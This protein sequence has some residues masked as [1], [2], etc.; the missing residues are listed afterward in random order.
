MNFRRLRYGCVRPRVFP[1]QFCELFADAATAN[2]REP[3]ARFM[4][5]NRQRPRREAEKE[6][7]AVYIES[8][9]RLALGKAP[10]KLDFCERNKYDY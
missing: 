10:N 3:D 1:T 8:G 7:S 5:E 2:S 4:A 6:K 9:C